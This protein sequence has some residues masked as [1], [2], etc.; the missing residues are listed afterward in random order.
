M[1]QRRDDHLVCT[2]CGETFLFS[3]SEA[4]V[5]AQRGLTSPKRC[6]TCRKARKEQAGGRADASGRFG[7]GP[8]TDGR[9]RPRYTGDVNE[10]RS[11]MQDSYSPAT[12]QRPPM[13]ERGPRRGP[14]GTR[15]GP[16]A[17]RRGQND[18][19][20]SSARP[21]GARPEDDG[22]YRAPSY[23]DDRAPGSADRTPPRFC[24]TCYRARKPA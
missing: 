18:G 4:A 1:D 15:P 5:F 19:A 3:A 20:A 11:P 12:W 6:K 22:N 13:P 2:S 21:R 23:P 16:A 8:R 14:V 17:N 24:Q 9:G 10:Y 7:A